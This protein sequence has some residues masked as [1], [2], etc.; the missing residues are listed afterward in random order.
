MA[1]DGL[2][3]TELEQAR[4]FDRVRQGFQDASARTGEIVH[5]FRVAGTLVR[6]RFAGEALIPTIVPGLAYPVP[7]VGAESHCEIC[8]WDSESTGV[9]LT[10]PPRP[11]RDFTARGNIWGFDSSRY[12]SAY[13]WGEGSVNVMDRETRRAVFWVSSHRYLPAWVLASPL[14]SILHWWM[15]LNGRQLVHAAAVGY[16]GSG[17]LI[18]GRGGS[19]KSSTSVACLLGGL[20]FISDDYLALALDPKPRVYRLYSTAKL[21]PPTLNLYPE[22]RTRCR[23]V[24]QPGF[25]KV[26]LFL[27]DGYREQLKESLPL[28]LVLKP[29]ISGVPDTTLE[30][31]EPQEIERALASETLVHLPHA[32][33]KTL[34]FLDRVSH[35]VPR[36]AILLGTDRARIPTVIQ[37]ALEAQA[38]AGVPRHG[39]GERRPFVSVIVHL[40]EEDHEELRR[41]AAGIE[42]QAYP[43]TELIV[44][45][46]GPACA[47]ADD[48]AK[49]PG[50]VR[51]FAFNDTVGNAEAWNRGIRESFAEL[52]ILIEPGDRFP[53][54][55]LDAL[56][57][58]CEVEPGAAW[59]QGR[60]VFPGP[61]D[62]SLSPLRGALIRKSAFRECGL[63]HRDLFLQDGEHLDWLKRASE[64]QLTGRRLETV[65][66]RQA[67][68]KPCLPR[69][70]VLSRLKAH[71]DWRR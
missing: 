62:E 70:V 65:T 7:S 19:G 57:G 11:R 35:E 33:L 48:V 46:A 37:G 2:P 36:A 13:Q 59:V 34:E 27:E 20:D 56:V 12:R 51:F 15:E 45:A 64:Q 60:V 31:V 69:E 4:F 54:G 22:L 25:D 3:S 63:F 5:D 71:P 23:A 58:A 17:V 39:A 24:H 44:V 66:L 47:M 67:S 49:L 68:A 38:S 28:K 9:P 40:C 8:L 10:P 61:E 50:T 14:R 16:G 30:P 18:P 55:A 43:G 21:D 53:L 6:L 52:L 1:T 29:R 41:L 42:E 26:V 32:G